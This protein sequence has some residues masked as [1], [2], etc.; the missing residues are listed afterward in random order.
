MWQL[1]CPVTFYDFRDF[2]DFRDFM[3]LSWLYVTLCDFRDFRDFCDCCDC[4]DLCDFRDLCD[5]LWPMSH[6]CTLWMTTSKP[7]DDDVHSGDH[8]RAPI[9]DCRMLWGTAEEGSKRS[10]SCRSVKHG[11]YSS[12]EMP[13]L[14]M[15][16]KIFTREKKK[17]LVGMSASQISRPAPY[18]FR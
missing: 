15:D 17:F 9:N 10:R 8:H 4:C 12:E 7:V 16:G 13:L 5:F 18:I 6:S 3:W 14:W 1:S 11:M 2:C